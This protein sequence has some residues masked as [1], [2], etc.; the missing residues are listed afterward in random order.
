VSDQRASCLRIHQFQGHRDC[1]YALQAGG[2]GKS[3]YSAGGDGLIVRWSLEHPDQGTPIARIDGSVYSMALDPS[4]EL[5]VA[6]RNNDGIH[7]IDLRSGTSAGS[8]HTGTCAIFDIHFHHGRILTAN[9]DGRLLS[10][11]PE[12]WMTDQVLPLSEKSLRCL[13][14]DPRTDTIAVGGSDHKIRVL[15]GATLALEQEWIGHSNS[16][17]TLAYAPDGSLLYSGARDARIKT[18]KV[19]EGHRQESETAAHLF[20]VNHIAFRSDGKHFLTCSMDKTIKV[21]ASGPEPKLQRVLDRARHAGHG[22]SVNRICWINEDTFASAGD[23]RVISI[24]KFLPA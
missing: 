18:W 13:A 15:N 8:V 14:I 10:I 1:I 21:W 5:L 19:N 23:D 17:F 24:W 3:L 20:A 16:I 12:R 6:G 11:D 22:N 7:A 9:G 2:D 4:G